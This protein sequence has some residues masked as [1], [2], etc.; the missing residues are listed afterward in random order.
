MDVPPPGEGLES[1]PHA[2]P[3]GALAELM[4]IRRRP[5]DPAE[6]IR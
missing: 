4:K 5:L 6:G 1:H 2:A 3:G